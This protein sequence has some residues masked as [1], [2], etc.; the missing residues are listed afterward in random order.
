VQSILDLASY[1]SCESKT[2]GSFAAIFTS[3]ELFEHWPVFLNAKNGSLSFC[4]GF[5]TKNFQ[6]GA[7]PG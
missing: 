1:I 7:A 3:K 6:S 2:R 5:L 4:Q